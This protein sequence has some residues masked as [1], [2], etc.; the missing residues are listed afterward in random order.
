MALKVK[1]KYVVAVGEVRDGMFLGRDLMGRP[2]KVKVKG[3]VDFGTVSREDVLSSISEDL[4]DLLPL[5]EI[6]EEMTLGE[7]SDLL[8]GKDTAEGRARIFL[9]AINTPYFR[10]EGESLLPRGEEDVRSILRMEEAKREEERIREDLRRVLKGESLP[11]AEV[12]RAIYRGEREDRRLQRLIGEDPDFWRKFLNAGHI[13]PEDVPEGVR[14]LMVNNTGTYT[15]ERF[16]Y[17]DLRHLPAFSIDDAETEDI[18]DAVSLI[19]L[20]NGYE[21][22]IHIALPYAVVKR[23]EEADLM[24]RER[25]A[26]L[27]LPDGKWHM[28]PR[29]AVREMSLLEGKDRPGLTLRVL[30][31]LSGEVRDYSFHLSVIRNRQRLTYKN[32]ERVLSGSGLWGELMHVKNV[33]RERRVKAGGLA[34][35]HPFLKVKY[36]AG[37]IEVSLQEPNDATALIGEL[38]ILYNYLAGKHLAERGLVGVFRIQDDPPPGGVPPPSDPLYFLKLKALGRPVRTSIKPGPHRGLGVP[39]YVRATSPIRRYS[40]VLNQHQ[41]LASL[42]ILPPLTPEAMERDMGVALAGELK[43]HKAQNE[44]RTHI[45]LH[46]LRSKGEVE[47]IASARRKVFL[48][49]VLMEVQSRSPL[50]VGT[51]CRFRVVKVLFGDGTAVVDRDECPG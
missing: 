46:Y 28:Y 2:L 37:R 49:E 43:R 40:D 12:L 33:L 24:A 29:E 50:K 14:S 26:T 7:A 23:G 20:G 39:Y 10:V 27:Y 31:D 8:F 30:L 13:T 45:L 22:Y 17:E 21:V 19:P 15:G 25:G 3:A 4:P 41:I 51:R 42:K 48:P 36:V 35:D 1:G 11:V 38:M 32:A 16:E 9:S 18:D 34:Y 47:G 44:R 6:G 5:W